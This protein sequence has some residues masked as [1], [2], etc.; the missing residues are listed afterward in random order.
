[1]RGYISA[2]MYYDGVIFNRSW[3]LQFAEMQPAMV[4]VTKKLK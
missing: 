2:D 3:I 1:M 4:A